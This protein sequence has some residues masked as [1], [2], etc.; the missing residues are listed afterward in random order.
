MTASAG[1]FVGLIVRLRELIWVAI[2]LVFIKINK[3]SAKIAEN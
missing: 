2:G 1:I 3:K